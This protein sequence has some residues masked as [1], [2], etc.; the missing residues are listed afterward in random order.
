MKIYSEVVR[1]RITLFYHT[2]I[3][4]PQNDIT[5]YHMSKPISQN[6]IAKAADCTNPIRVT[7]NRQMQC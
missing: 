3:R 6:I 4:F 5:R 1:Y 2:L 7:N